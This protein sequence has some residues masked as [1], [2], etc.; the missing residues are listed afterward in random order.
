MWSKKEEAFLISNYPKKGKKWCMEKL[1]RTESSV[2]WK[3]SVL[4][5]KQDRGSDFYKDW[6]KRAGQAKVGKKRPMQSKIMKEK[7]N[8]GELWQ[9]INPLIKHGLSRTKGYSIWAGMMRRCHS[10]KH[11]NYHRYGG[12]GITVCE[13]WHDVKVFCEWFNKHY[14]PGLSIDR[15]DNEKG[16]SP[17]NCQF[18]TNKEQSQNV[19]TNKLS[20]KIVMQIREMHN[21]GEGQREIGRK[22]SVCHKSVHLV[23]NN[24]T[25]R[26]IK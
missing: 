18:V 13:E 17:S 16:Y 21:E 20:P 4:G 19:S 10:P 8:N 25:W 7:A 15:T 14:E 3:A 1:Q 26:N 22:L 11:Q 5:L 2:R 23:V 9:Q 24:K 12:R 6:Q